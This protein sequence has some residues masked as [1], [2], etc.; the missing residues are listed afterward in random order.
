MSKKVLILLS[1]SGVYDGT[2][3]QE[4]TLTLLALHQRGIEYQCAAPNEN[5][6]HVIN[7]TN[8][9]EIETPRNMMVE[10]ARI[11]RGDIKDASLVAMDEYDGLVI[12]GGFGAAKNFSSWA[13]D[14]P[15]AKIQSEVKR[16]ILEAHQNK[17]PILAMCMAP[18]LVSLAFAGS[19]TEPIVTV[20]TEKEATPYEIGAISEGMESLGSKVN[21]VGVHAV[22][23]DEPN[24][25][26]TTPCYM[27]EA[28]ISDIFEGISK[29]TDELKKFL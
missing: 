18:V 28:S 16:L 6:F 2:E 27:M 3:I 20:G 25:T 19:A 13:F 4:A 26:I 10:S 14:G 8:G 23:V 29:A 24:K 7:H 11:A 21:Q 17:K 15:K 9:E 12:P 1:G 5:Q 22:V